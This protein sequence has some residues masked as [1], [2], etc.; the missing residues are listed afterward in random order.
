MRAAI[1]DKIEAR[2]HRVGEFDREAVI[3]PRS[4]TGA[5]RTG[6]VGRTTGMKACSSR[7]E[8]GR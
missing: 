3:S 8:C 7:G 2:C 5:C 1:G 6:C 4:P